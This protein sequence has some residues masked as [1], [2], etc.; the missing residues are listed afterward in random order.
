MLLPY[1]WYPKPNSQPEPEKNI[2]LYSQ[3][4]FRVW[5]VPFICTIKLALYIMGT[6][7]A[8]LKQHIP[9]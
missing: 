9:A 8:Q 1:M 7:I 5:A 3:K 4:D 6:L 2:E